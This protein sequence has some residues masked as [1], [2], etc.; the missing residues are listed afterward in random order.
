VT[1]T[2]WFGYDVG[3]EIAIAFTALSTIS[4]LIVMRMARSILR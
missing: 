2:F 4:V 1:L 3:K